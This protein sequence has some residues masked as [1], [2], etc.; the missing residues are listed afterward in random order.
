M[1][2]NRIFALATVIVIA[3][4]LGL[5]WLV[6]LSPL[7][8]AASQADQERLLV[9][10]T[11]QAQQATLASMKADFERLD[12]IALDLEALR[13]AVPSEV[14]S[15]VIYAYLARIQAGVPTMVETIVTGEAAPY[16]QSLDAVEAAPGEAEATAGVAQFDGLY[17]VPITITFPRGTVVDEIVAFAGAMQNGPRIFLVTAITRPAS[18][19]GAAGTI[20]A[21]MFVMAERDETPGSSADDHDPSLDQYTRGVI[22]RWG[23]DSEPTPAPTPT[24]TPTPTP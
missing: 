16:G 19:D 7:L 13:V 9:E 17:T 11:N 14:D 23:S 6:G 5:G 15:D 21:Y 12:E 22:A 4:V 2:A 3:G 20:T 10:Q 8:A 18:S 24:P 1:N